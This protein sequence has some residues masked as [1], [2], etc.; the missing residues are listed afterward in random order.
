M[1]QSPPHT[2]WKL[3]FNT[4]ETLVSYFAPCC[5]WARWV[6]CLRQGGTG[7]PAQLGQREG[8]APSERYCENAAWGWNL[9]GARN[10][11]WNSKWWESQPL[12]SGKDFTM[13][14]CDHDKQH[15]WR[16]RASFPLPGNPYAWNAA[17]S[18]SSSSSSSTL[19]GGTRD[20]QGRREHFLILVGCNFPA[21]LM[22]LLTVARGKAQVS[23]MGEHFKTWRWMIRNIK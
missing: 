19:A 18:T 5:S 15:V 21:W 4:T 8:A 13:S 14:K 3:Q 20:L 16:T 11:H 12:F 6:L 10:S 17:P 2:V 22:V 1:L 9:Q 7:R 23:S